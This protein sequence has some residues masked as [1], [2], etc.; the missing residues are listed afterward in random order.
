MSISSSLS[1]A[2]TGLSAASR[3][4]GLVS[5]NVANALTEGY[6]RRELQL[7]ARP[8]QG[9]TIIGVT[10][11]VDQALLSDRRTAEAGA[12]NRDLRAAFLGRLETVLGSPD[13]AG[14]LGAR[15]ATFDAALIAATS[16]PDSEARLSDVLNS[17]RAITTQFRAAADEIQSARLSADHRIAGDVTLVNDSLAR[18]AEMNGQI[19]VQMS[20]GRDTSGLLDQRQQLVDR[21]AEVMPLREIDRGNGQIALFSTGGAVLLDGK[22]SK[23]GFAPVG[24]LTPQMTNGSGLSG[25]TLNGKPLATAGS[26]SLVA[27]G[28]LAA[29]FAIRDEL[30]PQA[31]TRLDAVA[32]DLVERMADPAVDGTLAAG[33]AGLFTDAGAP[34]AAANE[35]G[36]AQRLSLNALADPEQGGALWRLRDGLGAAAPGPTGDSALLGRMQAALAAPRQTVSGGFMA[37][38]RSMSALASDL[39]SGVASARLAADAESSFATARSEALKVMELENGVD[40]DQEMQKLLQIE[41]AYAANAKVVQTVDD[42]LQTLIGL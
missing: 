28:S 24:T 8:G 10:R 41:Q 15:I 19:R 16:R 13:S 7:G 40:T 34:F 20:Q 9:V 23:F 42:L 5:S 31:Q 1:N 30:A 11:M 35:V 38:S 14:S 22:P 18:I 33:A 27:G 17:A 12:S 2:L 26:G 6:A 36:L 4:A 29:N 37:A 25:L 21:I 3:A 39:L 32:R